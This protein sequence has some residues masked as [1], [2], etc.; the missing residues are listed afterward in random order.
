MLEEALSLRRDL[1]EAVA[2]TRVEL[3]LARLAGARLDAERIERELQELGFRDTAGRAAGVLMAAGADG[4]APVQIQTLGGFRVVRVGVPVPAEA[5]RS[6]KARD[7]LK[8]LAARRGRPVARDEAIEA[9]WPE[10]DPARTGN[11][12]SVALS[13]LRSV[14]DP[15]RVFPQDHFVAT[16][17]GALRLLWTRSSSTS[18]RSSV[19]PSLGSARRSGAREE[20]LPLL[21]LAEAAYTGDFLEED[22][23]E[24]WAEPL[25]NEARVAY[26]DV[27]RALG[28]T[29]KAPKYF[30]RIIDRDPFDEQA[31]LGLV[32]AL[33]NAGSHGEA[34]RA[35]RT[36]VSRMQEIAAEPASFPQP[37]LSRV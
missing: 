31:H 37:A 34:R 28:E 3:A 15:E 23:Y 19:P 36:Y 4:R 8:I 29:T 30:L 13:T 20:A 25:R 27:L 10:E 26:V 32:A 24:D 9:L 6:K 7:L 18:N 21:E 14:L 11:R 1:G 16:A 22:R 33:Q 5:W 2:A 17:D 35:Y 12:L